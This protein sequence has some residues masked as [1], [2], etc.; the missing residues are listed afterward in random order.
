LQKLALARR[1]GKISENSYAARLD[2]TARQL[3]ARYPGHR[4]YIDSTIS[5]ITGMKPANE[6]IRNLDQEAQRLQ[7]KSEKAADK[8][9]AY[10]EEITK[11]GIPVPPRWQEMEHAELIMAAAPYYKEMADI[12]RNKAKL[13]LS[14]KTKTAYKELEV[15]TVQREVSL[16]TRSLLDNVYNATGANYGSVRAQ[17]DKFAKDPR[18]LTEQDQAQLTASFRQMKL[19]FNTELNRSLL[20]YPTLDPKQ[21]EAILAGP[22]QIIE[23]LELAIKDKDVGAL[24]TIHNFLEASKDSDDIKLMDAAPALRSLASVRRQFGDDAAIFLAKSNGDVLA[25]RDKALLGLAHSRMFNTDGKPGTSVKEEFEN[26]KAKGVK[27]REFYRGLIAPNVDTLLSSK[28][29][30]E[31][32]AK[33][34]EA[35]YGD[36]NIGFISKLDPGDRITVFRRLTS[37]QVHARL[38][39]VAEQGDKKLY[40]NYTRWTLDSFN[41]MFTDSLNTI[42]N[43]RVDSNLKEVVLNDQ[44]MQF[45]LV[46]NPLYTTKSLSLEGLN[47]VTSVRNAADIT[48]TAGA[49]T[50]IERLNA[51]TTAIMPILKERGI[52]PTKYLTDAFKGMGFDPAEAKAKYQ[53]TGDL[54]YGLVTKMIESV[55]PSKT[56]PSKAGISSPQDAI[57]AGFSPN[58]E[59][60]RV[61]PGQTAAAVGKDGVLRI[62]GT[63]VTPAQGDAKQLDELNAAITKKQQDLMLFEAMVKETDDQ[64]ASEKVD[65]LL[66]ELDILNKE[67]SSIY[68]GWIKKFTRKPAGAAP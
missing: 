38:K 18:S 8:K 54:A 1:Q 62:R 64:G 63:Q 13:E 40:D 42:R 56:V 39:Q 6:I 17:L 2:S 61:A 49:G 29:T 20:N 23:D 59:D 45:S 24:S 3:R 22:K 34:A 50:A 60:N 16:T 14:D 46:D 51:A 48:A 27:S 65:A 53:T 44:T 28:T 10:I 9:L 5:S 7:A 19:S 15:E 43:V 11:A 68:E 21:R 33:A 26:A 35:L 55:V 31:G 58:P 36:K 57:A 30:P 4:D 52:D 37:P 32:L 47:P 12:N 41:G 66:E 67:R 25:A